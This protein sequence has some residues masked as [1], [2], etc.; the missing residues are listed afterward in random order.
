MYDFH[1]PTGPDGTHPALMEWAFQWFN[2]PFKAKRRSLSTSSA[3]SFTTA[4]SEAVVTTD[5][6]PVFL[7]HRG[8]SVL[9]VGVEISN[10]GEKY[11]LVFDPN[12]PDAKKR[13]SSSFSIM[14]EG[15]SDILVAEEEERPGVLVKRHRLS[16]WDLSKKS[17][18]EAV[19]VELE[20][21]PSCSKVLMGVRIPPV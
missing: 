11:L 21:A 9:L 5:C 1:R 20:G 8:H 6:P 10:T 16:E 14:R 18:Y 2:C 17:E 15:D 3:H 7:Q 12:P 19:A 4:E 13:A